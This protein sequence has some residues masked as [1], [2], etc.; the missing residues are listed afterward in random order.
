MWDEEMLMDQL[1]KR[2]EQQTR[3][4]MLPNPLPIYGENCEIPEAMRVSFSDGS[5]EI[6]ELRRNGPAPVIVENIRIIRK[7]K[8]EYVNQP[9]ARRRKN[10]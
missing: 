5:T 3:K 8:Q 6:Y 10:R 1:K 2:R 9:A 4:R 7:W